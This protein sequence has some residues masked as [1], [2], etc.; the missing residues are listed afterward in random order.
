VSS[1]YEMLIMEWSLDN[2][3]LS[4][5]RRKCTNR[6]SDCSNIIDHRHVN[7][8]RERDACKRGKEGWSDGKR[9]GDWRLWL[10]GC[11]CGCC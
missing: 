7:I 10:L 2:S 1:C 4:N 3:V 6:H 11:C 8:I 5:D 9:I